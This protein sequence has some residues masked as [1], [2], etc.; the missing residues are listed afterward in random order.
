MKIFL[1]GLF[2]LALTVSCSGP[3]NMM[4]VHS[5]R[6]ETLLKAGFKPIAITQA[7][8][9]QLHQLHTGKITPMQRD[10][11]TY[12]VFPDFGHHRILVGHN[13][14]FMQYNELVTDQ[15][16]PFYEKDRQLALD[17]EESGVW[18]NTPF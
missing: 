4:R 6:E 3:L 8:E 9:Q 13:R 5:L 14:Q 16:T 1:I 18:D 10:G 2:T 7:Q 15:L 11:K 12:F 17:W